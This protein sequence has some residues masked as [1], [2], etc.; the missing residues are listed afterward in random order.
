MPY[1]TK[2]KKYDTAVN[3]ISINRRIHFGKPVGEEFLRDFQNLERK[4]K[5]NQT[6]KPIT[7]LVK[8]VLNTDCY[9]QMK[10][11]SKSFDTSISKK[12]D[13][14]LKFPTSLT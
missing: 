5:D 13:S 2:Y 7:T 12:Y 10:S 4:Q 6:T 3:D 14:A 11:F 8:S 1:T 9:C